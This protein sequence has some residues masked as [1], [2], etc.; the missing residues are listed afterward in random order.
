MSYGALDVFYHLSVPLFL[1]LSK[2]AIIPSV[3]DHSEDQM[4]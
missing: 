3:Q 2:E 4:R 1:H